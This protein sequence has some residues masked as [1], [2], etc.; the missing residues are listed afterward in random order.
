MFSRKIMAVV[1]PCGYA[2]PR[3]LQFGVKTA[4]AIFNSNMRKMIHACNGQGPL[5]CAQMI[6]DLCISGADPSEHFKNL[7]ELL[8]R[9]YACGLKVNR[10]K[11]KFYEDEVRFLGKIVDHRGVRLDSSTTDAILKMPAPIDKSQL[12]SFLGHLSYISRHVPD[13][14]SARAPLDNLI[15]PNIPFTWDQSANDAFTNSPGAEG[16]PVCKICPLIL[17]LDPYWGP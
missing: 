3:T 1:T 17:T 12:R 4:P 2:V 16:G 9:L 7:G 11:C 8:Y 5:N 6:D 14:R 15:K 10:S 13:L